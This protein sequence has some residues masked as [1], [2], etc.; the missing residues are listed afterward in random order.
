[1]EVYPDVFGESKFFSFW[2]KL[3]YPLILSIIEMDFGLLESF[4][5]Y[6]PPSFL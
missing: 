6:P 2:W 3:K 1:M 5:V 4:Q